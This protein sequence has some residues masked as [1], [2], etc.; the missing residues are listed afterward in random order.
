MFGLWFTMLFTW[1][2]IFRGARFDI[3]HSA[4][5]E[6]ALVA[7]VVTSHFC[8]RKELDALREGLIT[9]PT[10]TWKQKLEALDYHLHR[11]LACF[12]EW[13]FFGRQSPRLRTVVSP[14]MKRDFQH[15]YESAAEAITVI[16]NGVDI[17]EFHPRK[18][19]EYRGAIRQLH[20]FSEE[21]FILFFIGGDW[22]RKGLR[23]AIESLAHIADPRVKLLVVGMGD[24]PHYR[25]LTE[26]HGVESRVKFV[27]RSVRPSPYYAASDVFLFPTLYEPFGLVILEAMAT[28][29]PVIT[30]ASAGAADYVEDG[31]E[32]FLVDDPRDVKQLA[33]RIET[34]FKDARLRQAVGERARAKAESMSWQSITAAYEAA[35]RAYLGQA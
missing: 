33:S 1:L 34:L 15:Y 32:G 12:L 30:S 5:E 25:R 16:P 28:G 21:D 22:E 4:G 26:Q 2:R 3:V 19:T 17:E 27:L 11:R 29:L 35:Y 18:R 20:G 8:Q 10:Q 14:R 31:V 6:G 9:L 23:Y 7:N 13:S 24:E